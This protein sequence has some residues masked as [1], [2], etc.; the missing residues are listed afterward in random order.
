MKPR[1][2]NQAGVALWEGETRETCLA[3][4]WVPLFLC[5]AAELAEMR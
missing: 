2:K 3:D 4:L 5:P 1:E